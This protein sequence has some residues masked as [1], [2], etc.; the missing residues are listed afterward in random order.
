MFKKKKPEESK[1]ISFKQYFFVEVLDIGI[2]NDLNKRGFNIKQIYDV[3]YEFI[4]NN[5]NMKNLVYPRFFKLR[6]QRFKVL[7]VIFSNE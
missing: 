5:K 3:D 4:A 1:V 2:V 6:E 7:G